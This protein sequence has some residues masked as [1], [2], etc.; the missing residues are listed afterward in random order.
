MLR[1][2]RG[3][4][5]LAYLRAFGLLVRTPTLLVAPL[6]MTVI[7]ML[8]GRVLGGSGDALGGITGGIGQFLVFLLDSFGLGVSL[9]I[10][11]AAWRR[12][13]G[14]F[15]E[16]WSEA[17][18]KGGDILLAAVGLNF[19]IFIA[20][21]AGSIVGG[22]AAFALSAIALYFFIYAIPAAAIGGVPGGA[23]LQISLDR[24]RRS[25]LATL[26]VV[27]VSIAAYVLIGYTLTGYVIG[28]GLVGYGIVA[29][30]IGAVFR[31]IAI[32]YIALILARA[33]NDVSYG[34]Y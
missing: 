4:D 31:S 24:V 19:I 3:G 8:V 17:R 22:Y 30:L 5:P 28:T 2:A 26:L 10:A 32:A 1:G 23:A 21:Y 33:Y 34:R 29:E 7:G 6:L 20:S 15:E 12:G 14:S 16:G 13:R 9:I 11:D 27:V 18:R 25:Y